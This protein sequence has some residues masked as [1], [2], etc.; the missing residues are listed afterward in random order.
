MIARSLTFLTPWWALI[1]AGAVVPLAALALASSRE[2]RSALALGL[3]PSASRGI[4]GRGLAIVSIA[5]LLG[6]AAGQP[7][8]RST[9]SIRVR[10]D[11]QAYFVIDISRSMLAAA[12]PTA[13]T[14]LARA[15][16]AAIEIRERLPDVNAGIATLTDQ[17]LPDLLPIADRDTFDQTMRQAVQI[18][19]PPPETDAVTATNLGA[20]GALGTQNFFAPTAAHRIAIVFTDGESDTF[21]IRQ[22][23]HE[24]ANRPGV[25]PIFVRFWSPHDSVFD[26]GGSRESA[27]HPDP[28]SKATLSALAQASHGF[29]YSEHQLGAVV[30]AARKIL[31]TGPVRPEG[32]VVKT[33]ALAPYI[34]LAALIPLV[35]LIVAGG[36]AG[37]IVFARR[38]PR[39]SAQAPPGSNLAL[40][41]VD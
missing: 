6:L 10:T 1:A 11:A 41:A 3:K 4:V 33:V 32:Q 23:A 36:G 25:T 30:R 9:S 14:R 18:D 29:A 7:V 22:T 2:R 8:L 12:S 37:R 17:V 28:S 15:R 20:L 39:S 34:A 24:L 35:L 19:Q 31:G 27:Y 38:R 40:P 13:S 5:V 21:A 26:P 16:A